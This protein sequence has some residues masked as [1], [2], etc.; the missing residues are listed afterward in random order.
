MGWRGRAW[1]LGIFAKRNK[2]F[3]LLNLFVWFEG[4]CI[5][6]SSW[7]LCACDSN[8]ICFGENHKRSVGGSG[9]CKPISNWVEVLAQL[10]EERKS[11]CG[12]IPRRKT[13]TEA[14]AASSRRLRQLG[15]W[16]SFGGRR[17]GLLSGWC[18]WFN[19]CLCFFRLFVPRTVLSSSV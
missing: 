3:D 4:R 14:A 2:R 17:F 8:F 5:R 18:G 15:N 9:W 13:E 11:E 10:R 19:F 6:G 7:S 12:D 16:L 1:S